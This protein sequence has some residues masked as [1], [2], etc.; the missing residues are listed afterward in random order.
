MLL[1]TPLPALHFQLSQQLRRRSD[2]YQYSV[3]VLFMKACDNVGKYRCHITAFGP[4]HKC[5]RT[6]LPPFNL[7]GQEVVALGLC[8]LLWSPALGRTAHV[9]T[10]WGL[11]CL[12]FYSVNVDNPCCNKELRNLC[13]SLPFGS[14]CLEL[15]AAVP[16]SPCSKRPRYKISTVS[17]RALPGLKINSLQSSNL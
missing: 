10:V 7:H 11:K 9:G 14:S 5:P 8:P 12:F 6:R 17:Q 4:F 3:Q 16:I 2:Y 15:M 1:R 13:P